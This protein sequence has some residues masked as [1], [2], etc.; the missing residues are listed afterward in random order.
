MQR[1]TKSRADAIRNA[2]TLLFVVQGVSVTTYFPRIPDLIDQINVSF[3]TWGIIIG[4]GGLGSLLGLS[5]TNQLIAN[6][7]TTLVAKYSA[8]GMAAAIASF[9]FITDPFVFLLAN[10]FM[11]FSG[12]V[13]NISINAQAI[14][15]QNRVGKVLLGRFHGSWSLGAGASA[16][17]SGWFATF[18]PLWIHLTLIP[19]LAT[20]AFFYASRKMLSRDEEDKNIAGST[21]KALNIFKAPKATWILTLAAFL[22]IFP[23]VS[24]M[25]WST[26]FGR[27]GLGLGAGEAAV[28]YIAFVLAMIVGRL[29]LER[30]TKIWPLHKI[31]RTAVFVGAV[32]FLA[33]IFVA[34]MVAS[35]D[36][37]MGMYVLAVL[38]FVVGLGLSSTVPTVFGAAAF[39]KGFTAAQVIAMMSLIH[40]FVFMLAKMAMGGLAQA[41]TLQWAFIFPITL[42]FGAAVMVG[43]V[44]KKTPTA[45]AMENAY[46]PTGPIAAID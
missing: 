37:T 19:V 23:E 22:A 21:R 11:S 18:M 30:L 12:G 9:A 31:S 39:V 20:A 27:K 1:L 43:I 36:K 14:A 24:I 7:G 46:P 25:D 34:P 10:L 45:S 13:F 4:V 6:F 29:S 17:L 33:S 35:T 28:P 2:I 41:I 40:T 16:V 38:W 3:S 26:V 5:V 44:G 32:A 8:I 15:L 42:M